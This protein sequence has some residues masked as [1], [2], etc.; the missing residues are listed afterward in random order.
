M[1]GI[2]AEPYSAERRMSRVDYRDV[3]EAAAIVLTSHRLLFGT[4]ELCAEG[5]LNRQRCS[6]A[7]ERSA[8]AGD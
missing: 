3:A 8:Q 6:G 5:Y 4:F 1:S 2:L 7:D